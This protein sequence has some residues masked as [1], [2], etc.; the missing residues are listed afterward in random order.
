M[1]SERVFV[2]I[3][4]N[5]GDPK[6]AVLEA[7]DAL[8]R[9]PQTRLVAASSLY[10]SAPVAAVGPDFVNAVAELQSE[11]EPVGLMH[12]LQAIEQAGGRK[13]PYRHAPLTLDLD[14]LLYGQRTLQTPELT[15]PH[16][17]LHERAFVLQPLLQLDPAI[18]HPGLGP[19]QPF[20][21]ATAAQPI[22]KLP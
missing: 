16:P 6:R 4:A 2:G 14:L 7:I 21:R 20:L 9:L 22:E 5:L 15:L 19:L 11:L 12:A 10:G 18:V 1:R 3:G 17:R 13:R 8:S